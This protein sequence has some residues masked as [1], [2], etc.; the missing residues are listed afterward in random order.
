MK[1]IFMCLVIASLAIGA[2]PQ[3][4]IVKHEW[5]V[6]VKVIDEFGQP[7]VGAK[8]S[9]GYFTNSIGT[10]ISGLT[11]TNGCFL[12]SH[13]ASSGELGF[14]AEMN[15]YYPTRKSAYDLGFT[16]DPAI[17][18]PKILLVLK[19]I[20]SPIPMHAKREEIKFPT[21][22]EPIGFD[23]M[24]G[25]W[26]AP[27]GRGENIDMIFT[28]HRNLISERE[29]SANLA[30]TFPNRGDG[31]AIAPSE[32][33][34]GSDFKTPR[35]AAENGYEPQLILRYNN[36]RHPESVFGYFIRVRTVLD[37]NGNVKNALYGKIRGDF[38]FY[39]G[40]K[41]PHAGMGFDY[42]LNPIPNSRNVEFDPKRNLMKNLKPLEGVEAP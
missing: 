7:I 34:T 8:T 2:Y 31:I 30:V 32:P 16:Y 36:T 26:V 3:T 41:A 13:Y 5:R 22:D 4:T 9:V 39:A 17:W 27:Y 11:D 21:E 38:R 15:D 19:K 29:Y 20:G 35:V 25:D 24:I 14:A 18:N 42:Y 23:L 12:A 37:E 28:V 1:K 33:D 6:T 10:A 40:T